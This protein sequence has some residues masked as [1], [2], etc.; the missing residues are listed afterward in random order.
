MALNIENPPPTNTPILE[1]PASSTLREMIDRDESPRLEQ[2]WVRFF[3]YLAAE[4]KD[5]YSLVGGGGGGGAT[6]VWQVV[7]AAPTVTIDHATGT[8]F[9]I[10][11]NQNVVMANPTNL[12]ADYPLVLKLIQ[13]ATGGRAVTWGV[14]WPPEICNIITL[15]NTYTTVEC[16]VRGTII[17]H[18][19][20]FSGIGS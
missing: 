4:I 3:A 8:H 11:L 5:L 14:D 10:F 9:R 13:D 12:R 17:E 19:L 18:L 16:S 15:E 7:T 1:R 2:S 20:S 6:N